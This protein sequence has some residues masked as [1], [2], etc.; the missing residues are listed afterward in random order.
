MKDVARQLQLSMQTCYIPYTRYIYNRQN[1]PL[2]SFYILVSH[3]FYA[4]AQRVSLKESWE[5]CDIQVQV[6]PFQRK[7]GVVEK[8]SPDTTIVIE[9]IPEGV[10][11]EH[12][13]FYLEK[14]TKLEEGDEFT[15]E[16]KGT[17]ALMVLQG[18]AAG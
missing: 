9:G 15:L 12:L 4:V 18:E 14:V 17:I 11:E 16:H 13:K 3:S 2:T 7:Q 1:I 10:D 5:I 8:R 6:L